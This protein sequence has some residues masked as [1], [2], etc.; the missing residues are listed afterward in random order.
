MN[1]FLLIDLAE[2][3]F[4]QLDYAYHEWL[5]VS[6]VDLHL[7]R[8]WKSNAIVTVDAAGCPLSLAP[9]CKIFAPGHQPNSPDGLY[10]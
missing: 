3:F 10:H 4:A 9:P 5:E 1:R 8:A 7:D 2:D 6:T